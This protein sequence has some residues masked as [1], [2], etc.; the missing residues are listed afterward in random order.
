MLLHLEKAVLA[1]VLKNLEMRS[2]WINHMGPKC[3]H[4]CPSERGIEED[5][6][7]HRRGGRN[8]IMGVEF[9]II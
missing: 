2:S 4:R 3:H 8:V 1:D 5:L 9:R 7:A 6:T